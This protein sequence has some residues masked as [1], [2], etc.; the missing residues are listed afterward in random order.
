[1]AKRILTPLRPAGVF[2]ALFAML[3]V[4]AAAQNAAENTQAPSLP[5][6]ETQLPAATVSFPILDKNDPLPLAPARGWF[7]FLSSEPLSG[8]YY[9]VYPKDKT[10]PVHYKPV[11]IRARGRSDRYPFNA[12]SGPLE[13]YRMPKSPGQPPELA[14]RCQWPSG[15]EENLVVLQVKNTEN[16][17]ENPTLDYFIVDVG[18]DA[19]PAGSYMVINISG[20]PL[21][22]TLDGQIFRPIPAVIKPKQ[23][24]GADLDLD[25][26]VYLEQENRI[27]NVTR[28]KL[29]VGHNNRYI[30]CFFPPRDKNRPRLALTVLR[31]QVRIDAKAMDRMIKQ[32]E[33]D[34]A[35]E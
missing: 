19:F 30:A 23:K 15:N 18:D 28:S 31:E 35:A 29:Y 8:L 34:N 6:P 25:I 7:S 24:R 17:K 16:P 21:A 5:I 1:M 27:S 3:C 33:A 22:G 10:L 32:L 12:P 11:Y 20:Y 9:K 13:L 4:Q 2:A 26:Y 14:L